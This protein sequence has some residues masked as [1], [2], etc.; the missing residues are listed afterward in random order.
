M[1]RP[2]GFRQLLGLRPA[3]L[4]AAV[5]AILSTTATAARGQAVL[6]TYTGVRI[7]RVQQIGGFI[8]TYDGPILPGGYYGAALRLRIPVAG[9]TP[10]FTLVPGTGGNFLYVLYRKNRVAGVVSGNA[11]VQLDGSVNLV[12]NPLGSTGIAVGSSGVMHLLMPMFN[13]NASALRATLAYLAVALQPKGF[14]FM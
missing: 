11:V 4:L 8:G 2:K 12:I 6:A 9:P 13:A 14:V 3:L 10:L 5:V 1:H 7:A